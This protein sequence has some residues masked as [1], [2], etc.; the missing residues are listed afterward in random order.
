MRAWSRFCVL[1]SF[2]CIPA[3]ASTPLPTDEHGDYN[4][5]DL[6][7]WI[8]SHPE[9]DVHPSLRIG[10][11]RPGDPTSIL[12]L[13]VSSDGDAIEKGD[14]IAQIPW[15]HLIHPDAKYDKRRKFF[16]CRAIYNLAKELRLGERSRRAPY[17][18]YLLTQPRGIMPGEWT[19]AG[20]EFLAEVLGRGELPP[21]EETWRETFEETWIEGCSADEDDEIGRAAF[22]LATSRDEDTLMVPV[23]DMAN[24][25]NDPR[26]LN[27]RSFKPDAAGDPFRLVASAR[28]PP[29][30][31]IFN[32]Y[33][34]CNQCSDVDEKS[35]DTFSHSRTPDLFAN[36]GF[37]EDHPQNWEFDPSDDDED[38]SDDDYEAEF[39]FCL[40]R[41]P[42]SGELEALWED[43]DELPGGRGVAWLR[44]QYQRL[45]K[46]F[47]DKEKLE[48]ELV[49]GGDDE[50]DDGERMTRW[51]WES[52]WRYHGALSQAL[53]AVIQSTSKELEWDEL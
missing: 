35:C 45:A 4:G 2:F 36:F 14:V 33:N 5:S 32:S 39:E 41:D 37:V 27:T 34:R 1:F 44:T 19:A 11:E 28:I 23:Y 31:Q 22:W 49:R 53:D 40:E 50:G 13:F 24:H 46:I 12:G 25:S 8:K 29:G 26:R 16:S 15:S 48:G 17:V 18:R 7:E 3:S 20:K 21:Y 6:I 9:G 43:E 30:E 51:E 38:S 10:R 52:I 42:E 47:G